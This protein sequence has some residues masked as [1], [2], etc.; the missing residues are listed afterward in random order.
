MPKFHAK[1]EENSNSVIFGSVCAIIYCHAQVPCKTGREQQQCY[2]WICLCYNTLPCPSSM[3]NWKRTATV[4]SLDLFVPIYCHVQI[5]CKTGT[6]QQQCYLWICL[7][8]YTAMSKF[9]AKLEENSHSVIFGSVCGIIHC[10][11]Q[12]PCKTGREQQQCYLWICL[13]LYT[14]MPKFHAKL[15]QNSNSAIFGSV[16]AYNILPCPS[17]MQNWKRT[18]TVLSL[19]LF[20]L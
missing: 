16:C 15:E 4:L 5:P 9:P 2:L 11:A 7:C 8:L 20:V 14:A 10:Y 13:C 18:A 19:D 17:S 12:V 6:E 1:L 3:Q